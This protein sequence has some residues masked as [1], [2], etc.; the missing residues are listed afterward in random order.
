MIICL[1]NGDSI[2]LQTFPDVRQWEKEM[3]HS[4]YSTG[5]CICQVIYEDINAYSQPFRLTL[6]F[7]SDLVT[8][9]IC[10]YYKAEQIWCGDQ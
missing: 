3:Y 7:Y 6:P 2:P 4:L 8:P 10:F 9:F 1:K 5:L